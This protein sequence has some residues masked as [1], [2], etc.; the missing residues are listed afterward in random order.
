MKIVVDAA[1]PQQDRTID[2][3]IDSINETRGQTKMERPT[4]HTVFREE[5]DESARN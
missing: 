5:E 2:D 1:T 3:V 4:L